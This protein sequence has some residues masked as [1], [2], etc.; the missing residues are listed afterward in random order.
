[1]Q[2]DDSLLAVC[3]EKKLVVSTRIHEEVLH[4]DSRRKRVAE[5]VKVGLQIRI[6]IGVVGAE[7]LA[8]EVELCCFIQACGEGIGPGVAPRGV[9]AP[10]GGIV[11]AVATASGIGVDGDED[12]IVLAQKSANLI[13][14]P[15]SFGQWDIGEFW[16]EQLG[17][18]AKVGQGRNYPG[19][20]QP[21][22]GLFPKDAIGAALTRSLGTVTVINKDFH[23]WLS[24]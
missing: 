17:I 11:P 13:D 12:D 14:T 4:K 2:I 8:G 7:A 24:V 16:H 21:V 5:D 22:P 10:A 3:G 1:M 9:G 15:A 18:V 6:A 20:N 23:S 19:S